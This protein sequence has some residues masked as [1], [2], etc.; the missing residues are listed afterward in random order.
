MNNHLVW[1]IALLGF[2]VCYIYLDSF[3]LRLMKIKKQKVTYD[4]AKTTL[5]RLSNWTTWLT[6]LQTAG[7]A[8]IGL[9]L[10]N[11][12]TPSDDLKTYTFFS[13]LFFGTSIIIAA[14]LLS[15]LPSI[16]QGLIPTKEGEEGDEKNDVYMANLYSFVALRFG[17]F[18]RFTGLVHTY[19]LA[20]IIS[21]GL[22]V[23]ELLDHGVLKAE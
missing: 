4:S 14:W 8:A 5:D 9:L 21:F 18:G 19:F 12:G 23:F 17:R 10:K 3:F 20:G 16:Q 2:T 13:L 6:G 15:A 7:M 22:F 1:I 11:F